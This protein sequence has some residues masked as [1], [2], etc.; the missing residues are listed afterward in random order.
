[1]AI[2]VFIFGLIV[3]SF[4][5]CV[6]YRLE[7]GSGFIKGRSF[8]PHCKHKLGFLDLIPV[9]SFI[10]LKGRCRYCK[11]KISIQYPLVEI[12]TGL[13]F[14]LN[15]LRSDP[16][17]TFAGSD[18]LI[19]G[20]ATIPFLVIIFVYDLKHYIIPDKM[21]YPAIGIALIYDFLR[22]DL[23]RR[24]DLFAS[25]FGAAAFF[26]AIV[27]L[28]RGKWMGAGDI[29]LAFLMGLMLGYPNI[30]VALFLAFFIG[31]IMGAGLIILGKKTMKSEVPF[32]PFLV[33]GTFIA[34]F[35]GKIIINWYIS[36]YA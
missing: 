16:A 6:I 35:W 33:L 11:G 28:S 5:N 25:A 14:V 24:S 3:G 13:L 12:S 19:S 30:L 4:L 8:C 10:W 32:G 17:Q 29:K 31:A 1:M 23:P 9:F 34:L 21:V 26:T 20:F 15:F 18:L 27:L 7:Q 36:L 2:I 22:S